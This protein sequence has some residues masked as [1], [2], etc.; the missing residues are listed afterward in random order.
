MS[1]RK[2]VAVIGGGAWGTALALT[3][4]AAGRDAVLWAREQ[5]TVEAINRKRENPRYLPGIVLDK[6]LKATNDLD[7]ALKRASLVLVVTPAQ[8]LRNVFSML[9]ERIA[10]GVPTI[11]CAKGIEASS[12]LLPSAI[13]AEFLPG[14]LIG[15]LSGPSFARDVAQGLPTAVTVA[16]DDVTAARELAAF[17]SAPHFR[18][19]SS[20]DLVGVEL[21]GALKNVMGIAAGA[22]S[23]AGLGA[24]ALAAMVTRG[25]VEL[26][27]V[28]AALGGR[29]ETLMGLSGLGDLILTCGSE[30]SRNFRHGQTLGRGESTEGLPLAEGVATAAI[31]AKIA[32][33]RGIEA[34][35]I[36][37][38]SAL[39]DGR[40]KVSEAVAG[41]LARPLKSEDA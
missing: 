11:I 13:A 2:K 27:R 21:G 36:F 17:L 29:P 28:G 38:V 18:C 16:A 40:L 35:I 32:A 26:R 23:G 19:Y 1:D 41:L 25:F 4:I 12:G 3:M 30:Q 37:A 5:A 9:S 14:H 20:G 34:P 33:E 39:L 8:T 10:P 7:A 15:A 31:A 6:R 22:V 24:S